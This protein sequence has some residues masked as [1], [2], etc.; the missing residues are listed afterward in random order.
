MKKPSLKSKLTAD[1]IE[2]AN[3][4]LL[5]QNI[6]ATT[7]V[8]VPIAASI[9]K[10]AAPPLEKP[11]TNQN[12]VQ[13]TEGV[14]TSGKFRKTMTT[15]IG[16]EPSQTDRIELSPASPPPFVRPAKPTSRTPDIAK[17]PRKA[18]ARQV[19]ARSVRIT[20][21]VPEDLHEKLKIKMILSKQTIKDYLL[22]FIE[23]DVTG[24]KY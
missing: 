8:A 23:K 18:N 11:E 15:E 24:F 10:P 5:E 7:T 20:I 12:I 6:P 14:E 13:N 21:D 4:L 9:E 2:E 3:R 1:R 22:N 16:E 19:E 17:S